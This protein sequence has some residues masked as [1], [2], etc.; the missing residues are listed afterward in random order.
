MHNFRANDEKIL[1]VLHKFLPKNILPFQRRTSNLK[2]IEVISL[3][4]T[5][6]YIIID[7]EN[8]LLRLLPDFLKLKIEH[9]VY[10]RRRRILFPI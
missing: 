8:F 9:N 1:E 5:A 3:Y 7:S 10:N 4:L 6:E 2:G